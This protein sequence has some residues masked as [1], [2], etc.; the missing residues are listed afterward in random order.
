MSA[1]E[2]PSADELERFRQ[3]LVYER[4]LSSHTVTNYLRDL[5]KFARWNT[6]QN[7]HALDE[8]DSLLV[9][10][11]LADLHSK[12]LGG[13]SLQR[14]LSSLRTFYRFALRQQWV[15]ADPTSGITAPKNSRHLPR[16]MD[17]DQTGQFMAVRGDDWLTQRDRAIIEL[18]YSSGLRLAELSGLNIDNLDFTDCT[19]T[20]IGKGNKTRTVPVGRLALGQLKAWLKVRAKRVATAQKALFISRRGGRLSNR[21]IQQRLAELSARQG[22][23]HRV[24]PHMLRHSFASHLLESSG[25]LRAVQE[26]LGHANLSTTQIYTHLD[27]QHL[28]KI[29]DKA[30]PR[31]SRKTDTS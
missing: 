5:R 18:M 1:P 27:Y 19:V 21:A 20:V 9:R 31:A 13:A 15:A 30:H 26:L 8:V 16:V 3:H 14:W 7:L 28:A 22:L 2:T 17:A 10:R 11:C 25:D 23:D 12:G 29:Y 4:G 24:H 6:L